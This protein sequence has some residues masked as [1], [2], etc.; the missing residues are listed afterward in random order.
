MASKLSVAII[1]TFSAFL[2]TGCTT[3][4]A[5]PIVISSPVPAS[6]AKALVSEAVNTVCALSGK[7]ML[8]A[9]DIKSFRDMSDKLK[10]YEGDHSKEMKATA[11]EL[12]GFADNYEMITDVELP[13][14][15]SQQFVDG[16]NGLKASYVKAYGE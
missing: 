14:D 3:V 6:T 15:L 2:M 8:T 1:V 7:T 10:A 13:A 16:C 9:T 4:S 12:N 11:D 5:P